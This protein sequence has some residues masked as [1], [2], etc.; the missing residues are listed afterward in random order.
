MA[1]GIPEAA[2]CVQDID[3]QCVLQFT[4]LHAAGCALHRHTS[5]VIHRLEF[6]NVCLSQTLRASSAT[7]LA[8]RRV[9]RTH[10]KS[11]VVKYG[12]KNEDARGER[13][14]T[15]GSLNRRRAPKPIRSASV[16]LTPIDR[17]I[18]P[19]TPQ[20]LQPSN[21][22]FN[23]DDRRTFKSRRS[24]ALSEPVRCDARLSRVLAHVEREIHGND[25]S[26]GSPTETL[27]RLLL[28]LDDQV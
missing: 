4:L 22:I 27:L 3:V 12:R 13:P 25:P 14:T 1:S 15:A 16:P 18:G 2:I 7:T 17:S 8:G 5:R 24:T 26:A 28:P 21:M 10:G 19:G 6:C 20:R 11:T 23:V 9:E